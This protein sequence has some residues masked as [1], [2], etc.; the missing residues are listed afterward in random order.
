VTKI[1]HT[2]NDSN[3]SAHWAAALAGNGEA[4]GR[5]FDRHK[6]RVRRHS[7]R[8]VSQLADADDVVAITFLEAWRNRARVRL[9]DDSVLP[10]LLV[11]ATNVANNTN[12]SARRYRALLA[13]LPPPEHV[14]DPIALIEGAEASTAL[15]R[16]SVADRRVV[17]LCV[18]EGFS[19]RE[20][21]EALGVPAGTVKSRLSRAK[22]RLRSQLQKPLTNEPHTNEP[23]IE[24]IGR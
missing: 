7:A 23:L 5:V 10:W 22:Q 9:V 14:T 24:G 2:P 8:L 21:A 12:R 20:A 19:E 13:R 18:L 6:D 1:S 3:D 17:V 16:L 11:T 4:F 15:A